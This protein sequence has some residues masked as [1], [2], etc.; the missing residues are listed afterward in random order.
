MAVSSRYARTSSPPLSTASQSQAATTYQ[1]QRLNVV[2]RLAIEGHSK[3][4]SDGAS[5]KMYLKISLPVD[6][7]SP[8]ATIPLF[9]EDNLR[10][11]KAQ[12]HPLDENSVPY[13]SPSLESPLLRNA[14]RALNLPARSS[15]SF[16]FRLESINPSA[17]NSAVLDERYT[18]HIVVTRYQ[19]SYVL[20]KEFPR[21]DSDTRRRRTSP[22]A[23]FMAGIEVFVPFL[24]RP[25]LAPFLLSIPVPRCLSNYV[26]LRIFPPQTSSVASSLASLSSTD[27]DTGAWDLTSDP[28]VTRS[29]T[30]RLSRNGSYMHFAD[31]ESSDTSPSAG[32]GEGCI[33]EGT[34]PSAE[35][36]RVRWAAPVKAGQVPQT[37]DGRRRV[38]I[39]EVQGDTTCTILHETG[40]TAMWGGSKGLLMKLEYTATCKG[41]WSPGVATLLGLDVALDSGDCD[42]SWSD[43]SEPMWMVSGGGGFTGFAMAGQ[44]QPVS[45]QSSADAPPIYVL[46]SSPDARG[47]TL[48]GT[49]LSYH[50][51]YSS[52]T[53]P[54]LLRAPLPSHNVEDYSFEGSPVSTPTELSST[55]SLAQPSGSEP[56]RKGRSRASS[57]NS[58]YPEADTDTDANTMEE[59]YPPKTPLTV[60]VN[61]NELLPP[62]NNS[63]TFSISGTVVVTP[64][65]LRRSTRANARAASRYDAS[66]PSEDEA[67][68]ILITLPKFRVVHTDA[69]KLST[70]VCNEA[71][72]TDV[73]VHC[74]ADDIRT[75][76]M[77]KTLVMYEKHVVC[78]TQEVHVTVRPAKSTSSPTPKRRRRDRSTDS[79]RSRVRSPEGAY[80]DFSAL[81]NVSMMSTR[82]LPMRDGPLMIPYVT[83]TVIPLVT[84]STA[85]RSGYAVQLRLPAPSD[86][87]TE[88]LEFG[89]ALPSASTSVTSS[90]LGDSRGVG[91][92]PGPPRVDVASVS[93]EGVPKRF[94]LI[95]AT[96]PEHSAAVP[97]DETSTKD[98]ISWVR[99]YIG[100]A[101]GG[102]VEVVYLVQ[103]GNDIASRGKTKGVDRTGDASIPLDILLPTFQLRIGQIE[104]NIDVPEGFRVEACK[105]NLLH[106]HTTTQGRKL[107][108]YAMSE[109]FYPRVSMFIVPETSNL[110]QLLKQWH[111]LY[112]AQG[113]VIVTL[114]I[115]GLAMMLQLRAV[116]AE[117]Y[118]TKQSLA[119]PSTGTHIS[120]YDF[121]ET[122]TAATTSLT[123][124]S[125]T[126]L[127][128]PKSAGEHTPDASASL[129]DTSRMRQQHRDAT[130]ESMTSTTMTTITSSSRP[131][132]APHPSLSQ[133]PKSIS[134]IT[135][136]P[137]ASEPT[138]KLDIFHHFSLPH[139]PDWASA[140]EILT[141]TAKA[142]AD[143]VMRG[144]GAI[145]ELCRRAIYY[146]LDPP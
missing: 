138:S 25:P 68:P 51:P 12:V 79:V 48:D 78:D 72:G 121:A 47:A 63:F 24:S 81:R 15:Q 107:L 22:T 2:T 30:S 69:E 103:G 18:G 113:L 75:G 132:N 55:T 73:E 66:S 140:A 127:Q 49:S 133:A 146:P 71:E 120:G 10:I 59:M 4:G 39:H 57:T 90:A 80:S 13:D 118:R 44:S 37:S 5:I 93:V 126:S 65:T 77:A 124:S 112:L 88:W 21:R 94:E 116:N 29:S 8:G 34:F 145:W 111:R 54:S 52:G 89:L 83:A 142:A 61:M 137:T 62:P 136:T 45:R 139:A 36:I 53:S 74:A 108:H 91:A 28:H 20:P 76:H 58:R 46:P 97:F 35:R 85:F 143:P 33:L 106:Q 17:S 16:P 82:M 98:W 14:A 134:T 67:G 64:R 23:Q 105:T 7:V 32:S 38:G 122:V 104:V 117:L 9:P 144:L 128:P 40:G 43:D 3:K 1:Q 31:D 96:K 6:S 60:H 27:D 115:F 92:R 129:T 70:V 135:P 100:D 84:D 119:T 42:V 123:E 26:K 56:E 11:Q 19:V 95:A 50:D 109:F 110:W 86:V 141:E 101:G 99:V 102:R 87:D 130:S 114:V 131:P 41:L 125:T